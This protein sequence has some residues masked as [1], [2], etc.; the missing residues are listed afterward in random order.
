MDLR[1]PPLNMKVLPESNPPKSRILVQRLAEPPPCVLLRPV[2][3]RPSRPS[4]PSTTLLCQRNGNGDLES[5]SL[6]DIKVECLRRSGDV[7][8]GSQLGLVATLT[9]AIIHHRRLCPYN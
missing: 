1:I 7:H 6:E 5:S 4:P 3:P 9:S 8:D 2:E